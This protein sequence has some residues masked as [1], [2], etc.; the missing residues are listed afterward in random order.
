MHLNREHEQIQRIHQWLDRTIEFTAYAKS[1]IPEH[2]DNKDLFRLSLEINKLAEETKKSKGTINIKSNR[3]RRV[4]DLLHE[5]T[6]KSLDLG[7]RNTTATNHAIE[8]HYSGVKILEEIRNPILQSATNN[9]EENKL[10]ELELS[11]T[12][13][14][15]T[16]KEIRMDAADSKAQINQIETRYAELKEKA[17]DIQNIITISLEESQKAANEIILRLREKEK[18]VDAIAGIVSGRSIGGSYESSAHNERKWANWTRLGSLTLMTIIA[19]IIGHS[20]LATGD[21]DFNW[22]TAILRL[23]FS[24]ALSIPA[25]YLS[26]ESTRHRN[27]QYEFQQMSL[28]LQ[29]ITPY[30]ASLPEEDQ[31]KLKAEMAN[32]LFGSKGQSSNIDSYPIDIQEILT[33]VIDKIPS[34]TNKEGPSTKQP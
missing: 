18:E 22:K 8:I 10:R 19:L 30:I 21:A 20:L 16:L 33:K 5:F 26:R 27:K 7:K 4:L 13:A 17:S 14:H 1:T 11:I 3:M 29:A 24:A 2:P 28:E 25:A 12:S 31:H 23:I 6:K 9:S 15:N 32:R 34:N